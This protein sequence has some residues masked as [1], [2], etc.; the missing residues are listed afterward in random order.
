MKLLEKLAAEWVRE[1]PRASLTYTNMDFERAFEAGF[2]KARE[3]FLEMCN[4]SPECESNWNKLAI[5]GEEEAE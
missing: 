2:R 3:M 5:L 1:Q 4:C